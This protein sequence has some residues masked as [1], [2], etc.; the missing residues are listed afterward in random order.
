MDYRSFIINQNNNQSAMNNAF[1]NIA[2]KSNIQIPTTGNNNN[3]FSYQGLP[4]NNN[5]TY[6]NP[7]N[8]NNV[9]KNSTTLN[10]NTGNR[11]GNNN[12]N[13]SNN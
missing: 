11:Y 3:P 10:N 12:Q 9:T 6:Q 4:N 7:F 1:G 5:N 2:A 13:L 8:Q